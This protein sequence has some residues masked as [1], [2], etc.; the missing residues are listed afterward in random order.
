MADYTNN[1]IYAS[2]HE[3]KN[4]VSKYTS[5]LERGVYKAVLVRRY[6][7]VVGVYMT[8]VAAQVDDMAKAELARKEGQ[9]PPLPCNKREIYDV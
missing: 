5:L 9:H 3:F 8:N 6:T 7:T 4:N 2:V 1:Y